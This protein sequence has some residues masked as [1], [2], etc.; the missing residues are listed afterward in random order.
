MIE[1]GI[2]PGSILMFTFTRK[3]A[4]EMKERMIAKIGPQAKAV[5]I[6]TYHAFSSMLLRRFAHLVGYDKKLLK[7]FAVKILSYTTLQ[8]LK[9]R[10][11]KLTVLQST[12]LATT[13]RFKTI[14]SLYS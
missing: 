11:G 7:I 1:Q 9:F 12:L 14:I 4:M 2:N 10:I 5:T 8:K 13:K 6:C 3:A